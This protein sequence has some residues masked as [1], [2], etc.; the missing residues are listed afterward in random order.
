MRD[1]LAWALFAAAR[2]EEAVA[3][4]RRAVEEAAAEDEAAFEDDLA[5]LLEAIGEELDPEAPRKAQVRIASLE[6]ELATIRAE[7]SA[8]PQW[9]FDDDQDKWWYNQ[10]DKLV[11]G[12]RAFADERTGLAYAGTSNEH[13]WGVRKRLANAIALRDGYA[14]GGAYAKAW[15]AALP[16]IRAAYPGLSL[17]PQ[18]GLLPIGPDPGSG[19]WEFAHLETGQPATRGAD[20]RLDFGEETGLVFVLLP[21]GAFSMG[22]QK[23]DPGGPN[24]D[25]Q[26]RTIEEPVHAVTLSPF[27]LSKYE[28]TQSQWER[29]TGTNPSF[30]KPGTVVSSLLHPVEQVSWLDCMELLTRLELSLPSEAQWEYGARGGTST[31]WWTGNE[32]ES[33][34]GA[35]NLADRSAAR[36]GALWEETEDWPELDD[37]YSVHAPVDAL[38]PSPFGLHNVCGNVWEWCLDGYDAHFYDLLQDPDPVSPPAASSTRVI[39]GGSFNDAA[40]GTRSANHGTFTPGLAAYTLGLRPARAIDP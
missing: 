13:G 3:E 24:W 22:A 30:Y 33:L 2:F 9:T 23:D 26:A 17:S 34:R 28:M 5:R 36:I 29:F 37:G 8:L 21:G 1:T 19:L 38:R 25:P 40:V 20:G 10:L 32:R 15:E 35:V 14:R 31:P 4:E 12:I 7:L 16:A 39:R 11:S 27:F 18:L 6:A